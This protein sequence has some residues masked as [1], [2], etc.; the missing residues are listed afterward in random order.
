MGWMEVGVSACTPWGKRPGEADGG[1]DLCSDLSFRASR[2]SSRETS[3]PTW[4]SCRHRRSTWRLRR[5]ETSSGCARSPSNSAPPWARHPE[6]PRHPVRGVPGA[7]HG[8]PP[9]R[10]FRPPDPTPSVPQMSRQP[11]LKPLSCIWAPAWWAA[12]PGPGAAAWRMVTVSERHAA[13]APAGLPGV[14][15]TPVPWES[16]APSPSR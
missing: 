16:C 12:R 11:R 13:L 6:S 7:G 10:C 4:R 14:F 5:M 1:S 3:F 9:N 15:P 8:C 2:R